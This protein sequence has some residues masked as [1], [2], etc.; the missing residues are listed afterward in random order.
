MEGDTLA[1]AREL[2]SIAF[3]LNAF[4]LSDDALAYNLRDLAITI[5]IRGTSLSLPQKCFGD[6]IVVKQVRS[7]DKLNL[8]P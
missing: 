8:F 1:D 2:S 5:D 4:G 7:F 3:V 6:D